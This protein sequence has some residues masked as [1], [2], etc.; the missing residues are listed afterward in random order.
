VPSNRFE[1]L[2]CEAAGQAVKANAQDTEYPSVLKFDVLAQ[3]I[4]GRAAA[5]PFQ[6]DQLFAEVVSAWTFRNLTRDD[7]DRAVDYVATGGYA[8]RVYER[9]AKLKK[10]ADGSLRLAHPRLAQG[11]RLNIGTIVEAEMLKLRLASVKTRLGKRVVT[12]NRVLGELEE[13]FLS[14]LAVGDT[15]LFS[16]EILRFEGLDEFGALA[17]R[18]TAREPMIPSYEGGKFPL[19]TYLAERVR[20]LL[21][22]PKAWGALPPQV[23]NWLGLQREKSTI[24]TAGQMLVETFP[25]ANKH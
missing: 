13:W 19:S 9:Y 8:L 5:G 14:Q 22:D 25:R 18:T 17:S 7:F 3:H 12:G 23:R 20:G 15:F 2:E 4:L 21:A 10:L 16:G 6:P 1:V 24:P 11:Y